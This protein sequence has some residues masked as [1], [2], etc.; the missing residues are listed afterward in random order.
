VACD[1]LDESLAPSQHCDRHDTR[2]LLNPS[3]PSRLPTQAASPTRAVERHHLPHSLSSSP[4]QL[5]FP[6]LSPRVSLPFRRARVWRREGGKS[7]ARART[8]PTP[9]THAA[10][11]SALLPLDLFSLPFSFLFL[12]AHA[13]ALID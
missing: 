2:R 3:S 1:V 5:N 7:L 6:F 10:F 9:T 13:R 12:T 11:S 4:P 8:E